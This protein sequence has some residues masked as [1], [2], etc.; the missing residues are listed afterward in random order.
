M[1]P[2]PKISLKLDD[3]EIFSGGKIDIEPNYCPTSLHKCSIS[4]MAGEE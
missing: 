1:Q 2:L 3:P 4:T